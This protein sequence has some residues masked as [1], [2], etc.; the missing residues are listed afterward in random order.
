[1]RR[2]ATIEEARAAKKA[3]IED[4]LANAVIRLY[5]DVY[6]GH[7]DDAVRFVRNTMGPSKWDL[8]LAAEAR[9]LVP[10]G[11]YLYPSDRKT[12]R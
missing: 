2:I 6:R 1:M 8:L 7:S 11:T 9:G 5:P 10:R 4:L 12:R 3:V